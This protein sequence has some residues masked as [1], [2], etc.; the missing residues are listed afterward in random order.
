MLQMSQSLDEPQEF[1]L[2]LVKC[3]AIKG[4]A[5]PEAPV[6]EAIFSPLVARLI[7][8]LPAQR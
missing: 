6:Q 1:V 5:L 2:E 8:W 7:S 4:N 3:V